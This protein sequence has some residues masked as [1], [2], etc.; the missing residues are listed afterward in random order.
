MC[1]YVK[2]EL[3]LQQRQ[4]AVLTLL[5][6]KTSTK[7]QLTIRCKSILKFTSKGQPREEYYY[8]ML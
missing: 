4:T 6:L 5:F 1:R 7:N 3:G 8:G 2:D